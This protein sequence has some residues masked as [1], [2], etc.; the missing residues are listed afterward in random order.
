MLTMNIGE[1][2]IKGMKDIQELYSIYP[3][4]VFACGAGFA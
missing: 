3:M 2:A 1:H 4:V